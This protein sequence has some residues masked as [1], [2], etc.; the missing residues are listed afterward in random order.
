LTNQDGTRIAV[1]P[2]DRKALVAGLA[3][4]EKVCIGRRLERTSHRF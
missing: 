1:A 3:L 2:A 4:H